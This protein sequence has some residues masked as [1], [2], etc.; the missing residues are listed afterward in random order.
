MKIATIIIFLSLVGCSS[1]PVPN[2]DQPEDAPVEASKSAFK[3]EKVL[4]RTEVPDFYTEQPKTL[5]PALQDETLDRYSIEE[6]E[7]LADTKDPLV[8]IAIRC[9]KKDFAK[10]LNTA[11]TVFNRYQKIPAY[12]NLIANCHLNQGSSRKALLFYNKALEVGPGYVPAL[13]NIGVLYSRQG[14]DQKAL[15]A[16]EKANK[17]SRF[18]KT[19]RYNLARLYLSYGLADLALPIFQGLLNEAPGDIDLLNAVG[20]CHFLLGDHQKAV[21]FYSRIPSPQLGRAE[22]GLNYAVTLQKLGKSAEA[23]KVYSDVEKPKSTV[24]KD[25]YVSVGNQLGVQ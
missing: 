6:I 7:I 21:A 24:L 12:W 11:A 5:N 25:Y 4:A 10:A 20:S 3:K 9:S 13:N 14:E 15:V 16:F 1:A 23:Q 2:D 8:E 22:I 18:A 17:E 19:P